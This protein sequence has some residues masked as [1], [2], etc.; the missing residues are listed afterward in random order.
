MEVSGKDS[1][2]TVASLTG[3]CSGSGSRLMGERGLPEPSAQN[4]RSLFADGPKSYAPLVFSS[5]SIVDG[6]TVIIPPAGAVLEGVEFWE[7]CIVGQSL[8]KRLPLHVVRSIFDR[9]WSKHE[10]PEITTF[11]E[12]YTFR[13]RDRDAQDWVLENGPWY[14]AGR[15]LILRIWKP[16]MDTHNDQLTSLPIWVKFFNLP[17][18]Y[19]TSTSLG[20]IASVVG[21]PLHLDNPTK[22]HSRLS[23]ARIC[24]EVDVDCEFHKSALLDLGN[25]KYSTIRIKY[26]WVPH[27]CSHCKI[28]GHSRLNCHVVKGSDHNGSVLVSGKVKVADFT[29]DRGSVRVEASIG[30]LVNIPI[31]AKAGSD[32]YRKVIG[33]ESPTRLTGTTFECLAIGEDDGPLDRTIVPS[34]TLLSGVGPLDSSRPAIPSNADFSDSSTICE[35]FKHIK[36][37]EELD[38]PSLPIS[39]KKLKKLKK[40]NHAAMCRPKPGGP[41]TTRQPSEYKWRSGYLT[42]L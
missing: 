28:F 5:P 2:G 35:T 16:D 37:V 41:L 38:Y 29:P 11:D 39:K 12:L 13:F 20:Y 40:Q 8:D 3:Q 36:R 30:D 32:E 17:L 18:E 21:C 26:P 15:P 19:W 33:V 4:W 1:E 14:L 27:T 6:K 42:P 24:I 7:G 10:M 23:F 31:P 25:G 22:N 9:L 34:P